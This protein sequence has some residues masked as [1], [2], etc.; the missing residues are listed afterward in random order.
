VLDEN[1]GKWL[2]AANALINEKKYQ[3]ASVPVRNVKAIDVEAGEKLQKQFLGAVSRDAMLATRQENWD[4]VITLSQWA[5][6]MGDASDDTQK[7]LA[8][9][10]AQREEALAEIERRKREERKAAERKKAAEHAALV[11][12]ASTPRSVLHTVITTECVKKKG[13]SKVTVTDVNISFSKFC[14]LR[15]LK[16]WYGDLRRITSNTTMLNLYGKRNL[17]GSEVMNN[18]KR[19]K[20]LYRSKSDGKGASKVLLKA[21]DEWR[22]QFPALAKAK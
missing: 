16:I 4:E 12:K 5:I 1:L 19:V 8:M 18:H 20:V 14:G 22:K 9:A 15:N 3:S 2:S 17:H 11:K 21:F 13:L 6:D 10:R 7:R